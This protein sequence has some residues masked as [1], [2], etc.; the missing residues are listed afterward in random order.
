VVKRRAK[1]LLWNQLLLAAIL[2]SLVVEALATP[3]E[4]NPRLKQ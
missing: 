1:S 2:V 3:T 4:L